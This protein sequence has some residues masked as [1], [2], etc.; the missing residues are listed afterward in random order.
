MFNG[1]INYKWQFSIAM[2]VYQRVFLCVTCLKPSALPKLMK[3][4][5]AELLLVEA[6]DDAAAKGR[7]SNDF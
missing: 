2:L 1:K 3:V 5:A 6:R 4:S 7:T